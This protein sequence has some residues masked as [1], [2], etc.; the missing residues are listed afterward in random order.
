MSFATTENPLLVAME[1]HGITKR[2]ELAQRL[3][4]D[5]SSVSNLITARQ[6]PGPALAARIAELSGWTVEDVRAYYRRDP[7]PVDHQGA[8]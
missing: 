3:A 5:P 4:V 2:Y 1:R 8:A 7:S 6:W